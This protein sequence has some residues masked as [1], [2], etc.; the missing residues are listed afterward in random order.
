MRI[1]I[2][3]P[4]TGDPGARWKFDQ[5]AQIIKDRGHEYINPA[6]LADVIPDASWRDYIDVCLQLVPKADAITFL[7]GWQGS[8]G[9][10]R[11]REEAAVWG[12]QRYDLGADTFEDP[13]P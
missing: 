8:N 4:I 7:E 12:L 1:Y 10:R 2:S 9:A 5:A 3:G 6:R 13:E 11:E